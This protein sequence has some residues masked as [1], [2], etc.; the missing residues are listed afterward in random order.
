MRATVAAVALALVCATAADGSQKPVLRLV[1]ASPVVV[2][3]T[4]FRARRVVDVRYRSGSID[5]RRSVVAGRNGSFRLLLH[6]ISFTR[7]RGLSLAAGSAALVV[8]ACTAPSGR[9]SL[10]GHVAGLIRGNAF[11]PGEHVAL[12]ARVSGEPPVSG[13]ATADASGSFVTRL[14]VPAAACAEV[15][16]RAVGGLGSQATLSVDAPDCKPK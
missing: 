11:V 10:A 2:T 16:Y 3:G 6:G 9:P 4:H 1:Q 7:C 13:S 12:S 8:P 5:V 14:Q 15:F